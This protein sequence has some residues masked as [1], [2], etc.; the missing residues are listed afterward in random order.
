MDVYK[1]IFYVT[2]SQNTTTATK[3]KRRRRKNCT[4]S[5]WKTSIEYFLFALRYFNHFHWYISQQHLH[6]LYSIHIFPPLS[7]IFFFVVVVFSLFFWLLAG[8]PLTLPFAYLLFVRFF[9]FFFILL[10]ALRS[11]VW[12]SVAMKSHPLSLP[13][14]CETEF[15]C[16]CDLGSFWMGYAQWIRN[17]I[18]HRKPNSFRVFSTSLSSFIIT[19][20]HTPIK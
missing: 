15:P 18:L 8:L 2:Y 16:I 6:D 7:D 13:H 4:W 12:K 1:M 19:H 3:K 10:H 14:K 11:I 9:F 20:T 5:K 17:L